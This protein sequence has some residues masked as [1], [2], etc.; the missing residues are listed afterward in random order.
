MRA[1]IPTRIIVSRVEE[2]TSSFSS[3]FADDL[4]L[5]MGAAP[6][7]SSFLQ[8]QGSRIATLRVTIH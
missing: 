8:T 6:N 5:A 1:G 7:A 2:I 3:A 4:A